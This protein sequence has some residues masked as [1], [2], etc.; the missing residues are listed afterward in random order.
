L[1]ISQRREIIAIEA[2]APELGR[3]DSIHPVKPLLPLNILESKR[4]LKCGT[5]IE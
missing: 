1:L 2:A 3:R 5:D 4:Q